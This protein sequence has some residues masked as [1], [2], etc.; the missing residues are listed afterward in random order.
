[1][2]RLFATIVLALSGVGTA[3]AAGGTYDDEGPWNRRIGCRALPR[4]KRQVRASRRS[5]RC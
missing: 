3:L 2:T 4:P 1:M 5:H